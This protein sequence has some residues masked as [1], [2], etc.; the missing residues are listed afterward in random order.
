MTWGWVFGFCRPNFFR[1][2]AMF[3]V[4]EAVLVFP[5][6]VPSGW[7]SMDFKIWSPNPTRSI[8]GGI[9]L[10]C[11]HCCQALNASRPLERVWRVF[12]AAESK[13]TCLC[14]FSCDKT[15]GPLNVTPWQSLTPTLN[16]DSYTPRKCHQVPRLQCVFS[17]CMSCTNQEPD[18]CNQLETLYFEI[19]FSGK[20]LYFLRKPIQMIENEAI[21]IVWNTMLDW[22][23]WPMP[24][25]DRKLQPE[26]ALETLGW[27]FGSFHCTG[28]IG[29]NFNIDNNI[30]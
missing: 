30:C 2:N 6:Y 25:F 12:Y 18:V 17:C 29:F 24:N 26:A 22:L 21:R 3:L 7:P 16:L 14:I 10:C 19:L 1:A 4:V 23:G 20:P 11:L 27:H 5:R 13:E 28:F 15:A 8:F 9:S